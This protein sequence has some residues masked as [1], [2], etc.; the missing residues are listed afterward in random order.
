MTSEPAFSVYPQVTLKREGDRVVIFLPP[1]T[2]K[3]DDWLLVCQG[4]KLC[5]H[6]HEKFW[7]DRQPTILEVGDRLLDNRQLPTLAQ[8]LKE[9]DLKLTLV[10][11]TRRQTAITSATAGYSVEQGSLTPP[12]LFVAATTDPKLRA[13]P[14]FLKTTVR[15][16][17]D[18]RHPGS[19]ILV[20]D[21]NPGGEIIADGDIL[22]WGCLRGI[23]H[24]GANGD[25]DACIM[26]LRMEPT[27]LRIADLVARVPPASSDRL[28]PEIA[29]ITP[30]GIHLRQALNFAK[31]DP[32][33]RGQT[34]S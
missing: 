11:T 4:L 1:P 30:E 19:V 20:G 21:V 15:S 8:I 2:A 22:I 25:R 33:K 34:P 29:Y 14:L 12:P 9:N 24:A 18:I 26:A 3:E 32:F 23:A 5:L 6:H 10:R 31:P 13:E 7:G 27:Q 28:L 16:G 17:V